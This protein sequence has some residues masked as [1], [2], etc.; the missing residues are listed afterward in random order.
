MA[1]APDGH[2]FAELLIAL[3]DN[4]P[5]YIGGKTIHL[6]KGEFCLFKGD[7]VH[8]GESF[9]KENY[10]FHCKLTFPTVQSPLPT[11]KD[12]VDHFAQYKCMY[13]DKCFFE[14]KQ[15]SNHQYLCDK[16]PEGAHVKRDFMKKAR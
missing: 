2:F 9:E 11:N 14:K 4:T 13:C 12:S 7:V 3:E 1:L 10:R 15:R 6:R 8:A 5:F 16:N